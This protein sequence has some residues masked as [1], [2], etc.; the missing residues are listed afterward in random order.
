MR[1]GI[2]APLWGSDGVPLSASSLID[3][4]VRI[5]QTGFESVWL[6]DTLNRGYVSVEPLTAAAAIATATQQIEIGTAVLQVGRHNGVELAHRLLTLAMLAE[7]RF[8]L[9]A[10]AG[11]TEADFAAT[12][13]DFSRRF[14]MLETNLAIV[15]AL[16]AG[17]AVGEVDLHPWPAIVG[18][19]PIIVGSWSGSSWIKKAAT[20]FDGWMGSA[21]KTSFATLEAGLDEFR[22]HGGKRAIAANLQVDLSVTDSSFSSAAPLDLRCTPEQAAKRLQ[23]LADR[24]FDDVILTVFDHSQAHLDQLRS[25]VPTRT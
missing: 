25:L 16:F 15:K 2:S 8:T 3:A 19:L 4:V 11:S 13:A 18:Q 12:G 21:F 23:A 20:N 22:R 9:G 14:H 5:E 24:G 7:G 1:L 10:G 6:P 17:N